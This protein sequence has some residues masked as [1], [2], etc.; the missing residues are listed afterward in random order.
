MQE[1]GPRKVRVQSHR[2]PLTVKI[3]LEPAIFLLF[4]DQPRP[5]QVQESV[6]DLLH[7]D[8]AL[9]FL[10]R[11]EIGLQMEGLQLRIGVELQA[12]RVPLLRLAVQ[13]LPFS[14]KVL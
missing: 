13:S 6:V 8:Q 1:L 5:P 10:D 11:I 4:P 9:I 7:E 3:T 14:L 2:F 12:D